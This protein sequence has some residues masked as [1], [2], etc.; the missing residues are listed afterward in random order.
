MNN[1]K[2]SFSKKFK[3]ENKHF[4]SFSFRTF[5]NNQLTSQQLFLLLEVLLVEHK[6][7]LQG[8]VHANPNDE[9]LLCLR[10]C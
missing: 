9:Q 4:I 8:L 6:L 5:A 1:K 10:I 2:P 7:G 3:K